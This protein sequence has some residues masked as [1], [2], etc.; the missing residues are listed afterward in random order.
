[1]IDTPAQFRNVIEASGMS[2]P[3]YIEPGKFH[4]FPGPDKNKGNTAGWCILFEDSLGGCFGDWSTG[5]NVNWF[6]ERDEPLTASEQASFVRQVN[7]SKAKAEAERTKKHT[8][9]AKKALTIWSVAEGKNIEH[10][11]LERKNIEPN[12]VRINDNG[13]LIIPLRCDGKLHSLQFINAVGRKR[14]LSGGRTSG[15]YFSIGITKDKKVLCIAE[16]FATGATVHQA[17]GYPVAVAFYAGNLE[18]VAKA[19]RL[20]YPD[21]TLI[22]C[23]DDDSTTEGNPGITKAKQAANQA[24]AKVAV[25]IFNERRPEGATDFNDM[26][27]LVGLDKVA[28]T[29]ETIVKTT[30]KDNVDN[31]NWPKPSLLITKNKV[32]LYPIDA[33][34]KTI[35]L[36]VDE[37]QAFTKAP[38]PLVISSALAALSLSIQA[39][40]DVI[41]AEKL[42]GPVS[43]FLLT[44][45][46]SGE[47]K[48]TCDGFFTQPLRDYELRKAEEA[49]P[50]VIEHKTKIEAW[51]AKH[52]GIKDKIRHLAKSGK[53]TKQEEMA[54][55]ELESSKPTPLRVPRLLYADATPEAL[56]WSLAKEWPSGG[57]VSSEAGLVFGSHSMGKESVMRNLSTLNQLWDGSEI[58]TERRSSESFTV[59]GA[60]LTIALQVQ[61]L[62][63]KSFFNSSGGLARGTGFLARFLIACP[64]S[65][66]GFRPFTEPPKSWPAIEVFHQRITEILETNIPINEDG[67]LSPTVLP[68]SAD[69]KQAWIAFHDAIESELR[70]GG[71]MHNVR[72]VASKTADNAVRLATLFQV[73]E[74]GKSSSVELDAF[75]NASRIVIWHLHEARRFYGELILPID[76]ANAVHLDGWM[77]DRC[78]KEKSNIISRRELQRNITPINLRKKDD[79]DKA[80]D[81]LIDLDRIRI[82]HKGKRKEIHINPALLQEEMK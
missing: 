38:I 41:R 40:F 34:P 19:M 20:S 49:K 82:I 76:Q 13:A 51:E 14:F 68:L 70:V 33:L 74:K 80:L 50:L 48:S 24:D 62:T 12:G 23:A 65:T 17:T 43:L 54:L 1:M 79:L 55:H 3:T 15:C 59:R 75:E 53:N 66:Q 10:Y 9:I 28:S 44:I 69:A 31:Y 63:L 61:E 71:E 42:S 25:P 21:M 4:R 52:G 26:A 73:F 27:A 7:E 56:K 6:V 35:R 5:L 30:S 37:V 16:G 46:D 78:L 45:A 8:E 39:H 36:A 29:I 32:E 47:R 57:V 60:R 77:I 58:A 2:P 67:V 72:D 11:Y 18:A 64:E 81:E 22:I